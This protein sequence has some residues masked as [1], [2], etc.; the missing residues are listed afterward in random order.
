[1]GK[2]IKKEAIEYLES[3]KEEIERNLEMLK[4][5]E[6]VPE[7]EKHDKRE[8]DAIVYEEIYYGLKK[9]DLRKFRRRY[10][11]SHRGDKDSEP[12]MELSM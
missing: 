10:F 8:G 12:W 6:I 9:I 11:G 2:D 7:Y 5:G 1:M 4:S 3:F